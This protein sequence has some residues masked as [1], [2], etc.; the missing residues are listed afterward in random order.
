MQRWLQQVRRAVVSAPLAPHHPPQSPL[1]PN[2][3]DTGDSGTVPSLS[4]FSFDN[5]RPTDSVS[6]DSH[7]HSMA[8]ESP[9]DDIEMFMPPPPSMSIL[10]D[11][12][13]N[14]DEQDELEGDVTTA[15]SEATFDT[16]VSGSKRRRTTGIAK[17]LFSQ[18]DIPKS[19]GSVE[20][21]WFCHLCRDK[22]DEYT[23]SVQDTTSTTRLKHLKA[24][25]KD[26]DEVL[27]NYPELAVKKSSRHTGQTTLTAAYSKE[28]LLE[29]LVCLIAMDNLAIRLVESM[30][31][32][33]LVNLLSKPAFRDMPSDAAMADAIST[34]YLKVRRYLFI[35][36]TN[37]L[38]YRILL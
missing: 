12:D 18:M 7:T 31:L 36:S 38:C 13:D 15:P 14:D 3:I 8:H 35:F 29:H 19:D 25:H 30:Q 24:K 9:A 6:Q 16:F 23:C 20:K 33:A 1:E 4:A 17:R 34:V 21:K 28:L 32:R 11:G 37:S 22:G 27:D 26:N 2:A 5:I 10:S